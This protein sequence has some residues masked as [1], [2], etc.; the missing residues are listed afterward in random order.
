MIRCIKK[1][2]KVDSLHGYMFN[3][4]VMTFMAVSR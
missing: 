3:E 4:N 1:N 2:E